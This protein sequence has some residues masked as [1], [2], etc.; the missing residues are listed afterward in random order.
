MS[1]LYGF[2][3]AATLA[4]DEISLSVEKGEFV[5]VMG[6]SGSGKTTLMNIIGLLDKPSHGSYVLGGRQVANQPASR[7]ARL[8]RDQ[9]GFVF[10]SYNLLPRLNVLDNVSLP[11]AYKGLTP[12]RRAKRASDILEL[13]G[14]R[15]REYYMP[16]Q[17]AGGQAQRAAIA[18]ALINKPSI[19]I[20]DEPTGNLDSHD[21][22]VVMELFAEIHRQGNTV[23]LVTHNPELTRYA[24]RVIYMYDGAIVG[25]EQTA[26]GQMARHARRIFFKKPRTTEDDIAAG[27]SALMKDVPGA[28]TKSKAKRKPR[29]K[30]ASRSKN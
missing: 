12:V 10:Q 1:K 20:A 27:V 2:G 30:K 4:L 7:Q 13:V 6:P 19:I 8:R 15:D 21:S 29:R 17:L 11:L 3:D 24:S 18:R 26:I 25:D 22:R 28:D 23:L 9:I 14:M 16:N 5:A